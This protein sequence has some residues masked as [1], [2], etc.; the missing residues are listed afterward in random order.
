MVASVPNLD[1]FLRAVVDLVCANFNYYHVQIYLVEPDGQ[2]MVFRAGSGAAGKMLADLPL[3]LQVGREGIIGWVAGY[4]EPLLVNDVSR[5]PRYVPEP[6]HILP[7]TQAELA[8]P[9]KV[10]ERILGVLDVQSDR[11]GVLDEDDLFT[12]TTLADQIAIAIED[13]RLAVAQREEAWVTSGLLQLSRALNPLFDL[14]D[15]MA[16]IVRL[17]PTLVGVEAAAIYLW[18]AEERIFEGMASHG[19]QPRAAEAL[20]G[21]RL[22]PEQFPLLDEI[23]T[24][25][26]LMVIDRA[27][28]SRLVPGLLTEVAGEMGLIA[29][30]LQ[31]QGGFVGVLLLGSYGAPRPLSNRRQMLVVGIAQQAAV[32]IQGAML[33]VA[34]REE[35]AITGDLLQMAEMIASHSELQQI[36]EVVTRLAVMMAEAR[37]CV[38]YLWEDA[39]E[40]L[41]PAEA[42]GL[43]PEVD[44]AWRA[45]SLA[46][47][48]VGCLTVLW[49][50]TEP[51]VL[52]QGSFPVGCAVLEAIFDVPTLA[53]MPLRGPDGF[54]GIMLVDLPHGR[55]RLTQRLR[56]VLTGIA[57]QLSVALENAR[58]QEDALENE[59]RSQELALARQV[60][61]A[62]LPDRPPELPGYDI[63][64]Y[65]RPARE[66]A[67]DFYDFLMLNE[68]RLAFSIADVADKGMGAALFM[69]LT[70]TALRES[71]W[72]TQE[73]GR[74]LERTNAVIAADVRGGMFLTIFLAILSPESGHVQA[75]NAGHL[76]PMHYRAAEDTLSMAMPRNMP[77]A[78]LPDTRYDTFELI[79]HAGDLLVLTTD[80][81]MEAFNPQ[82]EIFGLE[83]PR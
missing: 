42:Y 59:R 58:L 39:S 63:A 2:E 68:G 31:A 22:T 30:P 17:V 52:G 71:L 8:V 81:I 32:A 51:V 5:E 27:A 21:Y 6:P 69:V 66:V 44:V 62:L 77:L 26:Q 83:A 11:A 35:A 80:G 61:S 9:L 20:V 33:L 41:Q 47:R 72:S 46:A 73:S 57:R 40:Q 55:I 28:C 15:V 64:G 38:L 54:L 24:R 53:A 37:Q 16:T 13:A 23:R 67:G 74:A 78:I 18:R 34:Q 49:D 76:P 3:R 60:Q 45:S 79:L 43:P 19:L 1:E 7:S 29:L 50:A 12:M 4:G 48:D 70:R 82:G 14:S 10:E 56:A 36:L 75:A 25:G 65:W